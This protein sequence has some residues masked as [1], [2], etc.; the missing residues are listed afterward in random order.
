MITELLI[1]SN[2]L[3]VNGYYDSS[4]GVWEIDNNIELLTLIGH[5]KSVNCILELPDGRIISGSHDGT[6]KIWN[7]TTKSDERCEKNFE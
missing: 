3:L 5:K 1:L 4:I 6:L 2:G 7:L